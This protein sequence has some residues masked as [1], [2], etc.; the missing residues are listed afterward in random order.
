MLIKFIITK[1]D[2][3]QIET[4]DIDMG[5]NRICKLHVNNKDPYIRSLNDYILND[6]CSRR[7]IPE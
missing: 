7:I 2:G 6:L 5:K 4:F 1:D 3:L